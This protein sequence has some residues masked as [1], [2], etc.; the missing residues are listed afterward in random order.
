MPGSSTSD[1]NNVFLGN[2]NGKKEARGDGKP[3]VREG[4]ET[5]KKGGE[6]NR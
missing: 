6:A 3:E 2:K 5:M 4:G 1:V